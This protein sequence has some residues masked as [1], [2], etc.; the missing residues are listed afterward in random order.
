MWR[1]S[2]AGA[3]HAAPNGACPFASALTIDMA[4]LTELSDAGWH[5]VRGMRLLGYEDLA[6]TT[7]FCSR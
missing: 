3:R 7:T 5:F 6:P 1:G 2:I 4:L